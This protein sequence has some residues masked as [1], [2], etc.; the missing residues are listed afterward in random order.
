[1]GLVKGLPPIKS[2]SDDRVEFDSIILVMFHNYQS[3]KS[4]GIDANDLILNSGEMESRMSRMSI[5][6]CRFYGVYLGDKFNHPFKI[7]KIVFPQII[8]FVLILRLI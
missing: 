6:C 8:F 2:G 7:K 4:L 5:G 1:M 3:F